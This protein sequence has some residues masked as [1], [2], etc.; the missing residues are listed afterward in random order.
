MAVYLSIFCGNLKIETLM[1]LDREM[2]FSTNLN[3]LLDSHL[4]K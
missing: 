1:K 3:L 4:L 2:F